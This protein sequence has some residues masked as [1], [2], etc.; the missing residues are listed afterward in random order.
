[1]N[2]YLEN[3]Q[4]HLSS[5]RERAPGTISSYLGTASRFLKWLDKRVPP[6]A[7]DLRRYFLERS[8]AGIS[9]RT[10]GTEFVQLKK[11]YKANDWSW[12]LEKEDR[13]IAQEDPFA[14]AFSPDEVRQIIAARS[15]YSPQQRFYLAIATTYGARSGEIGSITSRQIRDGTITIML[16]KS[17]GRRR[18]HLIP[19]QI[20]PVISG[21]HPKAREQRSISYSFQRIMRKSGLGERPG[22][23]FHCFRRTVQTML[24]IS[25]AKNN[26]PP[27][28]S[29]QWMG[30]AKTSI[31]ARYSQAPMAG[32]YTHIEIL[33]S[34]D[35]FYFDR[36]IYQVH[37]F[38]PAW[39]DAQE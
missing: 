5:P 31:G 15:E 38:L 35:P 3:L 37:P 29:A 26:L 11:L 4:L 18:Q 14:P 20:L 8:K 27:S 32:I 21:W 39:A 13:P 12:P 28:Y 30:W 2:E 1:M 7:N 17:H 22:W 19:D 6:S 24:E 25:L 10:R 16:E 36:L 34:D 33:G 9:V 23:G